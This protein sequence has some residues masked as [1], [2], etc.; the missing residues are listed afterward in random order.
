MS[1]DIILQSQAIDSDKQYKCAG[2][3]V[4][5]QFNHITKTSALTNSN[6]LATSQTAGFQNPKI[7]ITGYINTN[8]TSG[9]YLTQRELLMFAQQNYDNSDSTAIY[10]RVNAGEQPVYLISSENPES[11]NITTDQKVKVV[12]ESFNMRID[13]SESKSAHFWNYSITLVETK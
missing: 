3:K 2:A 4:S 6:S 13:A 1:D 5:Y 9:S 12:V 11:N 7:V 10:L 8:D